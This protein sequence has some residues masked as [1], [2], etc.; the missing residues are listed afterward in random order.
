MPLIGR[1]LVPI[2]D[3]RERLEAE[4]KARQ[5]TAESPVDE[6][7]KFLG[8]GSAYRQKAYKGIAAHLKPEA[9]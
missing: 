7:Y 8:G 5:T 4:L 6:K 3:Q 1:H 2:H 9:A